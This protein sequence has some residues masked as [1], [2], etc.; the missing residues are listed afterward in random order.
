M[1]PGVQFSGLVT[2]TRWTFYR[3][4][5]DKDKTGFGV[6]VVKTDVNNGQPWT[7][8]RY[9]AIFADIQEPDETAGI[10]YGYPDARSSINFC[11]RGVLLFLFFD[12]N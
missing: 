6:E 4:Y 3:V 2:V 7:Y 10:R 11:F 8:I 9:E 1:V 5:L 12:G